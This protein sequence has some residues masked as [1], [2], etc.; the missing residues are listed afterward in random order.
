MMTVAR[1][2]S[3]VSFFNFLEW[4]THVPEHFHILSQYKLIS[5]RHSHESHQIPRNRIPS[6]SGIVKGTVA[7]SHRR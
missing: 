4:Y 1:P 5:R 7:Y 2:N 6:P 3:V